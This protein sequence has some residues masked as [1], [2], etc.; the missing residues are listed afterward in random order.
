MANAMLTTL[1]MLGRDDMPNFG[2]SSG[3]LDLNNAQIVLTD[4]KG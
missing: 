1:H 2:D 3:E 4:A